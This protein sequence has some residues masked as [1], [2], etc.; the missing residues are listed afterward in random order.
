MPPPEDTAKFKSLSNGHDLAG[1]SVL[2]GVSSGGIELVVHAHDEAFNGK[3]ENEETH[4]R[5]S[6]H[7]STTGVSVQH[8]DELVVV[9]GWT[10]VAAYVRVWSLLTL[11]SLSCKPSGPH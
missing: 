9:V 8:E 11:H 10:R 7:H 4:S 2:D 3:P 6:P 1:S 5:V